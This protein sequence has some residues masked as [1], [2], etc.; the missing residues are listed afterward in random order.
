M[1]HGLAK[2][3][4]SRIEIP[5]NL[6]LQRETFK[7]PLWKMGQG[8]FLGHTGLVKSIYYGETNFDVAV[9]HDP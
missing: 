1:S 3:V 7:F 5:L 4:I 8:G 2:V 9:N 6:P